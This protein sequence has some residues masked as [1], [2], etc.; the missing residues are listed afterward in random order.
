MITLL[1]RI[2]RSLIDSGTTRNPA[3]PVSGGQSLWRRPAGRYLFYAIGEIALVVIG[4]LIALQI[5]NWNESQIQDQTIRTYLQ[6]L[7]ED[8]VV[9]TLSYRGSINKDLFRYYSLQYVLKV[10]DQS[11]YDPEVTDWKE[12]PPFRRFWDWKKPIPE[13]Y[14]KEFFELALIWS[15]RHTSPALKNSTIEE[16]KSTGQ[17]SYIQNHA[18][19]EKI[20]DYYQDYEGRFGFHEQSKPIEEDWIQSLLE[21]GILPYALDNL[22]NPKELFQNNQKRVAILKRVIGRAHF[23]ASAAAQMQNRA[24]ALMQMIQEELDAD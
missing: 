3:S 8:L 14:D 11:M 2:R 9:D 1:R 10:T 18:L 5:N 15:Y 20:S 19:K 12:L 6:N 22:E 21:E 24:K 23:N 7:H 17:Y 13:E 16:M 4:I